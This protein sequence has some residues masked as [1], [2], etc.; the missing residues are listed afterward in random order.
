MKI[1][2]NIVGV[3]T[4]DL[5]N[6]SSLNA[7]QKNNLQVGLSNFLEK[8]PD[9]LLPI[10]FYRG[11][12]FQLM[13]TK[14]KAAMITIIIEAIILS[15]TGTWARISVG[16]G[17]TSK[18]TPCNVLQSE[19]EAF[20]LSGHQMDRMKEEGRLLKIAIDSRQFQPILAATFYLAESIIWNWKPG[21]ASV[22]ALIPTF[23]TQ[24]EIAEKL[25]ISGSAV[26]K[27]LKSAKWPAIESFLNGYEETIKEI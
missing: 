23:K 20:Q 26:S 21:Q 10:Q 7:D 3:I 2:K 4:G 19:G 11:D 9:V 13:V 8:N 24:K 5:I 17:T 16:I 1:K 22:I 15:T 12:S 27:A 6:S 25:N 14:E 18:I